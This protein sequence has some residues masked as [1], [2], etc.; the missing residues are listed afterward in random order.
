MKRTALILCLLL[1]VS[2]GAD[3]AGTDS[4][5]A[6]SA[7]IVRIDCITF[8]RPDY[9]DVHLTDTTI[10]YNKAWHVYMKAKEAQNFHVGDCYR[11]ML[12]KIES[13]PLTKSGR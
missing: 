7:G 11:V 3:P 9:C 4:A 5:E 13:K 8:F 12:T 6:I 10:P 1:A 2:A